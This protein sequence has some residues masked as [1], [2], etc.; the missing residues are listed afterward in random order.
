MSTIVQDYAWSFREDEPLPVKLYLQRE[1]SVSGS[2][3]AMQNVVQA[4]FASPGGISVAAYLEDETV[5]V[6][7]ASLTVSSVIYNTPLTGSAGPSDGWNFDYAVP[8]TFFPT[9]TT[10]KDTI[11]E[12]RFT[13][14]D[15]NLWKV[16]RIKGPVLPTAG[17]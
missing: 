16:V 1:G 5:V 6:A 12:F 2:T 7:P 15:G 3:K 10:T 8:A 11:V 17:S 13:L 14:S 9:P 4:D